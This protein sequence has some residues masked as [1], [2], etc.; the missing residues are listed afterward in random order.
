[1]RPNLN[2]EL[3]VLTKSA[4]RV[5]PKF[6]SD[7]KSRSLTKVAS[8]FAYKMRDDSLMHDKKLNGYRQSHFKYAL[9]D[10]EIVAAA[11]SIREGTIE[12]KFVRMGEFFYLIVSPVSPDSLMAWTAQPVN[13]TNATKGCDISLRW[14]FFLNS[15]ELTQSQTHYTIMWKKFNSSTLTYSPVGSVTYLQVI[16]TLTYSEPLAPHI[17]VDRAE[18]ATLQIKD[19]IPD[20]EG[21]YKIEYSVD[22]SGI[23]LNE[24]EVNLAV[25]GKSYNFNYII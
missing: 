4:R 11:S 16:G 9:S 25:Y 7:P 10:G 21:R 2:Q 14:N 17:V 3:S 23:V 1:M 19:V 5:V 12:K 18:Q 15:T 13:P 20:D 8:I 6:D 22:V 24:H